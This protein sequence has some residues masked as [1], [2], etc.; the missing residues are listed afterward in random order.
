M[1]VQ[2]KFEYWL[3]HARYDLETAEAMLKTQRWLYVIF[4]CQQAVEKL[5]K[6]LYGVYLGFDKIPRIHNIN[7]LIA[8]FSDKFSQT[9]DQEYLD[10][11]DLLTNY[12]L[13]NRYPDYVGSLMEQANEA[14]SKEVYLKAKE[15]FAW[16]L[17][18]KP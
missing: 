14:N 6:G 11:L 18:L 16:L 2:E 13:N 17:T 3:Q 1:D 4:M 9:I 15:V 7:A 5:V 12:Y 8:R 10:F